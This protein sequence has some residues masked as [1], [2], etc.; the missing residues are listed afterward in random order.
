M[1]KK[2]V[3]EFLNFFL[4]DKAGFVPMNEDEEENFSRQFKDAWIEFKKIKK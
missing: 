1:N 3:K 4:T 2:Q